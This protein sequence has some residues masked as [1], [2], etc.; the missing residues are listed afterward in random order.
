MIPPGGANSAPAV[1]TGPAGHPVVRGR[2]I[3]EPSH[4][5]VARDPLL[6]GEQGEAPGPRKLPGAHDE[7][8]PAG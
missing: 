2:G 3:R 4:G 8:R 6:V 1:V 5:T 7:P